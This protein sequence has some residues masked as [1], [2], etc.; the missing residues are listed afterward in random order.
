MKTFIKLFIAIAIQIIFIIIA[1][2]ISHTFSSLNF[3]PYWILGV[4]SGII[5]IIA[6]NE[7][8]NNEAFYHPT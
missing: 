5:I 2:G 3:T 7:I 1:T 6:Y 8:D 4:T